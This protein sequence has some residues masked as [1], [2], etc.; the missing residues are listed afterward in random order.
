MSAF[1]RVAMSS[2]GAIDYAAATVVGVG[3]LQQDVTAASYFTPQVR[4]YGTGSCLVAVTAVPCTIG[5]TMFCAAN[6]AVASTGTIT[7]GRTRTTSSTNGDL[8]ELVP[9]VGAV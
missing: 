3:V 9:V 6:G 1:R 4:F 7:I 8:I 2:N 5:D